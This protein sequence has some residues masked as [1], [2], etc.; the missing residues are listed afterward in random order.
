MLTFFALPK[1]FEGH[2]GIIQMNAIQSWIKLFPDCETILFGDENGTA[3]VAEMLGIGHVP[4]VTCNEYGTPLISS[5][6]GTAQETANHD[7]ICYIN[8]DIILTRSFDKAIDKARGIPSLTVGRRWDM[9]ITEPLDFADENWESRLLARLAEEGTRHGLYGIDYFLF[10]RKTYKGIPPFA[11]GRTAWDNWLIYRA[12]T[13][14]LPVVDASNLVTI[15]HQN[16]D[17]NHI[18]TGSAND[19]VSR[20]GAEG[21]RNRKLLGSRHHLFGLMDSTHVLAET[22]L[23]PTATVSAKY[24]FYFMLRLP[25]VHPGLIPLVPMIK[26]LR[27][28][29]HYLARLKQTIT[30]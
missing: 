21:E 24:L 29:Y 23:K 18:K 26:L 20:K 5:F 10:P 6:F 30:T 11:I 14:R 28:T 9:D 17:F 12:R 27:G 25:E 1:P 22:G 13:L 7:L 4:N 3:Q 2:N 16:H 19:N 15:I 8:S